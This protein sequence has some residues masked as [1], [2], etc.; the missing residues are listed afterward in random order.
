[1]NFIK[2]NFDNISQ[3][4][5]EKLDEKL[6]SEI[7]SEYLNFKESQDKKLKINNNSSNSKK[8]KPTQ[9]KKKKKN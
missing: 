4:S 1:M 8:V 5:F 2:K 3:I 7:K 9:E 6:K